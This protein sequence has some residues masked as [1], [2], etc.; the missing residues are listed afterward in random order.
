[1]LLLNQSIIIRK[2]KNPRKIRKR[3][4]RKVKKSVRNF[5]GLNLGEGKEGG[6]LLHNKFL[7]QRAQPENTLLMKSFLLVFPS[8]PLL[9]LLKQPI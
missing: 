9:A 4:K 2:N 7:I 5:L 6:E 3:T 8:M 1:M